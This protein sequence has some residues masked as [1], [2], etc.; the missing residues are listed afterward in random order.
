MTLEGLDTPP[1]LWHIAE[2]STSWRY[3]LPHFDRLIQASADKVPATRRKGY[4]IYAIL[5]A[6][7]AFKAL[8]K[9]TSLNVPDANTLI[10]GAC[11]D[12]SGVWRDGDGRNAVLNAQSYDGV[13]AVNIPQTN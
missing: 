11:R 10:K 2:M 5:V 13:T 4:R 7:G 12:V 9:V 8:D 6:I 1:A 3:K